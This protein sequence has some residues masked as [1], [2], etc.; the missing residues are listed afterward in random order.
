MYVRIMAL[1]TY[2]GG[3]SITASELRAN[4]FKIL[5][6]VLETGVAVEIER[7]GRIVRLVPGEKR[8]KLTGL[9][10]REEFIRGEPE[11]L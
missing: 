9:P 8:S 3:F 7:K 5:D 4:I 2:I 10:R 11:D 1:S 6:E